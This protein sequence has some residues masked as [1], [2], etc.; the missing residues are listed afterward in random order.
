MYVHWTPIGVC[1]GFTGRVSREKSLEQSGIHSVYQA[2]YFNDFSPDARPVQFH[3]DIKTQ[4]S[5]SEPTILSIA[6]LPKSFI[7]LCHYTTMVAPD[8]PGGISVADMRAAVISGTTYHNYKH[9]IWRILEHGCANNDE[10]GWITDGARLLIGLIKQQSAAASTRSQKAE[11]KWSNLKAMLDNC[12]GQPIMN[13]ANITPKNYMEYLQSHRQ[14]DGRSFHKQNYYA[15]R[16]SALFH[17]FRCHDGLE[18]YP[19]GFEPQL[20]TLMTGLKRIIQRERADAGEEIDDGKKPMSPELYRVLCHWFFESGSHEDL[21]AYCFLVLTWNLMCRAN[22]TARICFSHLGWNWDSLYILFAQQKG[23]QM[24]MTEKF[25]RNCYANPDSYITCP[26]FALSVYLATMFNDPAEINDRLFPGRSQ[27]QRFALRLSSMLNAHRD[28]VIAMGFD[29]EKIGTHSVRK[30]ATKWL[31]AQPGGPSSMSI[32]IRG[33]WSLGGVKDVYMTYHAEG[34]HFCGRMLSLLPLLQA[35]FA[36]SPPTFLQRECQLE[37]IYAA[38]ELTF[39]AFDS[40]G[41]LAALLQRCLACLTYHKDK[42]LA[43]DADHCVRQCNLYRDAETLDML[44]DDVKVD[45]PWERASPDGLQFGSGIPPHVALLVSQQVIIR[46]MDRFISGFDDRMNRIFDQRSV[47]GGVSIATIRELVTGE[48]LPGIRE[49]LRAEIARYGVGGPTRQEDGNSG[50]GTGRLSSATTGYK[51]H[52]Y[53]GRFHKVPEDW[54]I[55]NGTLKSLWIAWNCGDTVSNIPP[56]RMLT[57]NDVKHLEEL[58]IQPG[59]KG[60]R[61]ARKA[62]SDIHKLCKYIRDIA[63]DLGAYHD[64]MTPPQLSDMLDSVASMENGLASNSERNM[65]LKWNWVMTRVN[66][67]IKEHRT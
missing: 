28:E 22:N 56:L 24:G 44:F 32:C 30:G 50:N 15:S 45:Y 60:R 39:P 10:L 58:P 21:F 67:K 57:P 51:L 37:D 34:D 5:G 59:E 55:P 64:E 17:L 35:T 14:E 11:I 42:V 7:R 4:N 40:R 63:I 2:I 9:E 23:D 54:R 20:K 33:G 19:E 8:A 62:L 18:G 65:Q 27:Y 52:M 29:P 16:T 3:L 12:H 66:E 26:L 43:L 53:G 61:K 6:P 25:A 46:D 38:V 1:V 36:S 48:L 13:V 47:G 31:S 49:E 41:P